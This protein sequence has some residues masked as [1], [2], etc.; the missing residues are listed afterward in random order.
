MLRFTGRSVSARLLAVLCVELLATSIAASEQA[1]WSPFPPST[2][3]AVT[4]QTGRVVR[5]R[6]DPRTNDRYL[7]LVA[8]A[9]GMTVASRLARADVSRI[10]AAEAPGLPPLWADA[11]SPRPTS[12][13]PRDLHQEQSPPARLAEFARVSEVRSLVVAA[14]LANWDR[15]PQPDGVR[16]YLQPRSSQGKLVH[17]NGTV[18]VRLS[19]LQGNW[20]PSRGSLVDVASWSRTITSASY[21]PHGA[22]IDLPFPNSRPEF[23]REVFP[24]GE[25]QVRLAVPGAGTF[26]ARVE[27]LPLRS[28]AFTRDARGL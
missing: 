28:V 15:D 14:E 8:E 26:D 16:V 18:T 4:T 25:L 17:A 13:P 19:A 7:W 12:T 3:V 11:Q 6:I 21:G 22:V 20:H 23:G 24:L 5:G 10:E 2:A 1:V 9:E 27:D